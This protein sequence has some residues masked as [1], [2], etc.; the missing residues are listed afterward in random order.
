[1]YAL[2]LLISLTKGQLEA[3][4]KS[5]RRD[6]LSPNHLLLGCTTSRIRAGPFK[7]PVKHRFEFVQ[8]LVDAFWRRWMRDF[9]PSLLIHAKWYTVNRNVKI[10]DIF[11]LQ[12]SNQIRGHWKLARVSNVFLAKMG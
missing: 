7:E 12:N 9:F 11:I 3:P 8:K 2:K 6:L 5:R 4:N 1:M 10:G